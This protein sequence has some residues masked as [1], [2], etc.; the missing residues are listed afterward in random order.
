MKFQDS[1]L[2]G[3]KVRVG[4]KK[5]DPRNHARFKS[6]M[7][8][9]LFQGWGH[10]NLSLGINTGNMSSQLANLVNKLMHVHCLFT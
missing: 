6:N 7:P 8:H 9:Q 2:N 4:T 5:C 10:N 1:S 3:L